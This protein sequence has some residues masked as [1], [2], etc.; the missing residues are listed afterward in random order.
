MLDVTRT[1]GWFTAMYPVVFDLAYRQ[2]PERQLV[3]IK[4]QLHR[5]PNKGIGYGILRYLAGKPYTLEPEITFNYLGDFGNGIQ[6]K[7]GAALFAFSGDY[8]G[9]ESSGNRRRGAVLDFSG[10]VTA[11]TFRLTIAYSKARYEAVTIERLLATCRQQLSDLIHRLS[12]EKQVHVTPVD[13]TYKGLTME[14]LQALS[15]KIK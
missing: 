9:A 15:K 6:T 12:A 3:E 7:E 8:H 1:V 14:Q 10:M 5:I 2:D 4:E 13:L 11:D